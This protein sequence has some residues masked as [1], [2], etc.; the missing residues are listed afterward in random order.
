MLKYRKHERERVPPLR[1]LRA[2]RLFFEFLE[3]RTLLT[4]FNL[5]QGDNLQTTL[6]NCAQGDTIIL[7]AGATFTGAFTLPAKSG[8]GTITIESS[9]IASLSAGTRVGP[10]VANLMPKIIV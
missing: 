3:A 2:R 7:D 5:H 9:A 4:V 8:S 1:P 6:T 10:A